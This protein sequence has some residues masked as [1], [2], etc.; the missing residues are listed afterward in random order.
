MKNYIV[1]LPEKICYSVNGDYMERLKNNLVINVIVDIF[2]ILFGIIA[3]I[4]L[5]NQTLY[6]FSDFSQPVQ[7]IKNI[8]STVYVDEPY[9]K[10]LIVYSLAGMLLS[11]TATGIAFLQNDIEQRA[12][13]QNEII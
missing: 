7:M 2:F 8:F 3:A 11:I 13:Q 1:A 12:N 9:L 5:I 4:V 10:Q 6:Y